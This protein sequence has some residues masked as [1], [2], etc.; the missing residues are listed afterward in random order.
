VTLQSV[1]AGS[2]TD[3]ATTR[4][5]AAG[6]FSF[7][8][9][10]TSG[11]IAYAVYTHFDGGLFATPAISFTS[12]SSQRVTL[13]VYNTTKSFAAVRVASTAILVSQVNQA[14]GLVPVA[15]LE[16]FDNTGT[17]AYVADGATSPG[18]PP[19]LLRF[20][21]P[22]KAEN[23]TLGA[24]F[25]GLKVIQV[26]TGFGAETTVPPGQSAYAFAYSLPYTE[27]SLTLPF[28]AEYPSDQVSVLLPVSLKAAGGEFV[29]ESA[30]KA[31]GRTYS[32]VGAKNVAAGS[33][34]SLRISGLPLAGVDPDFQFYQLVLLGAILLLLLLGLS[35]LYLRRGALAVA[36]GWV[37]ATL[38]SP[39]RARARLKSQRETEQKRLLRALIALDERRA[40]GSISQ[41]VY[42]RQR[43]VLHAELRPLMASET[44]A[45]SP[46]MR[47]EQAS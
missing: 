5:D 47:G 24:G 3:E 13:A 1:L 43:D 19:N 10:D 45:A 25:S 15:V 27:T 42:T 46:A 41:D 12:G 34:L 39:G 22:S 44:L 9:L 31:N 32:V 8:G 2:V 40:A 28:K 38:F 35:F 36:F 20:S 37:P 6:R 17:T 7:T 21:L 4:T 30:V 14:K 11:L 33:Q 29:D 26:S 18:G 23:L 16:T